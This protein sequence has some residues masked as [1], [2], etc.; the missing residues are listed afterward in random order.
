MKYK[1]KPTPSSVHVLGMLHIVEVRTVSR[2]SN[3]KIKHKLLVVG[4]EAADIEKKIK[5]LF[6]STKY[7]ELSI[8]SVEK[9]REKVHTISTIVTQLDE[10]DKPIVKHGKTTKQV[11]QGMI[12]TEKYDPKLFAIGITT[13]ML[14]K[15]EAHALRKVGTALI[16]STADTKSHGGASLSDDSTIAIEEIPK[17]SGYALPRNVDDEI[18][19]AHFVRG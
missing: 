5:W 9:V 1:R 3:E 8:S 6:D 4:S 11:Y 12:N 19:E 17:S 16:N 7:D 2:S 13:T 14:A 10:I 15:D 18:N